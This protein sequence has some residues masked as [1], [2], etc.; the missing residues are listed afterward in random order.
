VTSPPDDRSPMAIA[1]VWVS[2]LI[3]VSFEMVVPGVIGY[4]VDQWLNT[5]II[6]AIVG[7][8]LGLTLGMWHLVRMSR[9]EENGPRSGSR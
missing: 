4:L 1:A 6:F 5:K 2:R 8:G 9:S 7:F 3:A